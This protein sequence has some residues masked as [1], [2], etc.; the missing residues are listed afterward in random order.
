MKSNV[1]GKTVKVYHGGNIVIFG[2]ALGVSSDNKIIVHRNDS[3]A[4]KKISEIDLFRTIDE[5]VVINAIE[6][7]PAIIDNNEKAMQKALE[8]RKNRLLRAIM[9]MHKEKLSDKGLTLT[10]DEREQALQALQKIQQQLN[11]R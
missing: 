3:L 6:Q 1:V 2:E 4:T 9:T 10:D 7:A 11:H 8:P 5:V